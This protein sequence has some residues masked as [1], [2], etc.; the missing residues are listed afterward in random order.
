MADAAVKGL[1][2]VL[3]MLSQLGP[4][5]ERQALT[6]G[7]RAGGNVVRDEAR[8]RA[9]KRT[10]RMAKAIVTGSPRKNQD[11]TFSVRVYVDERKPNGFLGWFHEYGVAPHLVTVQDEEKPTRTLRSGR[12]EQWSMKFINRA[13]KGGSLVIGQNFV[14]P[15]VQHPGHRAHPFMRP[16]LDAKQ[17]E[18]VN[19]IRAKI[20]DV[21]EGKTGFNIGAAVGLD[22]AA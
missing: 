15:V 20:I 4:K 2:E 7:M 8:M 19:A 1:K 11:G 6:S 10:G 9:P 21:V 18:V 12:V 13:V 5:I 17:T 3:D 22:E 14:G 16:A